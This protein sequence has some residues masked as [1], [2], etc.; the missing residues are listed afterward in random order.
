MA[1]RPGSSKDLS[2]ANPHVPMT[3]ERACRRD[4]VREIDDQASPVRRAGRESG[5]QDSVRANPIP[6][7]SHCN[8]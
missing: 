5:A 1:D 8:R 4:L 6:V 2:T 7:C 3:A